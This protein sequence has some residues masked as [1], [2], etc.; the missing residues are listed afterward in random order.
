VVFTN[1]VFD[2]LHP[3]HVEYLESARAEG[4]ALVVGVNAD[5]SAASLGKGPGRPLV[6]AEARAR[7][8]AGLGCVDCVV[9]FDEATPLSLIE[10]LRPD[11][12]VK[13]G[14]Y[15]RATMAGADQ[16]ESWGGRVLTVPLL[17]GHSTTSLLERLRDSS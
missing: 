16:V 3:G 11:V 12:L 8:L 6:P 10:A 7:V 9:L 2:L 15:T 5:R 14:D 4:N 17:P 13:G 1:G